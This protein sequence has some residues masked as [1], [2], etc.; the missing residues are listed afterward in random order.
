MYG[1][2]LIT[3]TQSDFGK[4]LAEVFTREGYA[5]NFE[6]PQTLDFL[7]ETTDFRGGGFE[8]SFSENVIAPM[9][10]L[11]KYL[12]LLDAGETRRLF[13]VTSAEASINETRDANNYPYKMAKAALHQFL[14]MVRNRLAP[15][16]YTFRVFDPLCDS[17]DAK[18]A[19]ESAFLYITR[20]R[21]TEN[22]DPMR[23][24]ENNLLLRD[25][26]GKQY[27]W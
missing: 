16:G 22:H 17:F 21:G 7:V 13:Y 5:V 25:A 2:V 8:K 24:D 23:D 10:T 3:N 19:A 1:S 20:R 26:E 11:E 15:E 6:N 18:T 9:A 4:N 12:P 27:G 14:Q